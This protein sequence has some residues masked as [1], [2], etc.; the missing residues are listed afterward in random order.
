MPYTHYIIDERNA[1]QAMIGMG[2]RKDSISAILG[3]DLSSVY[4]ELNRNSSEGIYSGGEA[5]YEAEIRRR[6]AKGSPKMEDP[7]LMGIVMDMFKKDYLR[8]QIAGRLKRD[9]P[10]KW[11]SQERIYQYL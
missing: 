8:D 11:V 6:E 9:Y 1:L 7:V 3:K 10:E 5:H 4:G 2:L